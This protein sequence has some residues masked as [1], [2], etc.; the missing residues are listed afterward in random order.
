MKINPQFVIFYGTIAL[1][2]HLR[3]TKRQRYEIPAHLIIFGY[4][5]CPASS[6]YAG[7][8]S[9]SRQGHRLGV[10]ALPTLRHINSS[11][12]ARNFCVFP[13]SKRPL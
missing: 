11:E 10:D 5:P 7:D 4:R 9:S 6:A 8:Y 13:S 12:S 2:C 1:W 3:E